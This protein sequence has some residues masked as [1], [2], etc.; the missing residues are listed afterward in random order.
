MDRYRVRYIKKGTLKYISHLDI[1]NYF[2]R[3]MVRANIEVE[4]TQ[5]YNP[6]V[7][8]EFGPA[9]PVGFES[10]CEYFNMFP[11]EKYDIKKLQDV[12]NSRNL[13]NLEITDIKDVENRKLSRT[14]DGFKFR[15]KLS[16]KDSE[17]NFESIRNLINIDSL[18]TGEFLKK[19]FIIN[20]DKLS[21][22]DDELLIDWGTKFINGQYASPKS[23]TKLEEFKD[24]YMDCNKYEIMW[25]SF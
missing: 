19:G 8:F 6:K 21:E 23:I 20:I 1:I 18:E 22:N 5:G 25:K 16:K 13:P 4:F 24:F 3:L 7:K 12:L 9:L 11:K 10:D 17:N 14:I 15:I 2:S